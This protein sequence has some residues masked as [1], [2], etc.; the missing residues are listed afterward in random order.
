MRLKARVTLGLQEATGGVFSLR[1]G[2][3]GSSSAHLL[4]EPH[5]LGSGKQ[6]AGVGTGA[7]C[8]PQETPQSPEMRNSRHQF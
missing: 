8:L 6:E 1:Q 7:R 5:H 4:P 2:A 3:L